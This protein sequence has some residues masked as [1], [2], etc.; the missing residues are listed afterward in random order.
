MLDGLKRLFSGAVATASPSAEPVAQWAQQQEFLYRSVAEEG[1]VIDGRCDGM[2]WRMEWGPTQRPYWTGHELRLR[3]EPGLP[4]ELQA[5]VMTRALQETLEKAVFEQYVDG[6]QTRIDGETPPEMR[7]LVMFPK[8]SGS[9]LGALR[10]HFT[11]LAS[12]KLWLTTWLN[13]PLTPALL[14][15][16]APPVDELAS[17]ANAPLVLTIGRGRLTLRTELA[18]PDSA[19]LQAWLALFEVAMQQAR[20]VGLGGAEPSQAHSQVDSQAHS[21]AH[22]QPHSQPQAH[23]QPPLPPGAANKTPQV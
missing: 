17:H 21:Q 12:G 23:S 20:R 5:V 2:A 4:A 6:V 22:S 16:C 9:E 15:T 18:S 19:G 11:A 10:E 8:L 14:A 3:A 1:F 13:G 7:W